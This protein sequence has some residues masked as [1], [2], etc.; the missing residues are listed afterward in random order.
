[1]VPGNKDFVCHNGV[2]LVLQSMWF[3]LSQKGDI[4]LYSL[5]SNIQRIDM[6]YLELSQPLHD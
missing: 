4:T 3:V 6:E 2:D 1:M 5:D